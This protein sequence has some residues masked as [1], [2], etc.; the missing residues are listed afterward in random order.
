MADQ[1]CTL[2]ETERLARMVIDQISDKWSILVVATLYRGPL[3]FNALKREL[4]GVTQKALTQA[5]RRLERNGIVSRRVDPRP[6]IAVEYSITQLGSTLITPVQA[7]F[8]WTLEHGGEVEAARIR[9]DGS[10]EAEVAIRHPS[11][12][13][14]LSKVA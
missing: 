7:L 10:G 4:N 13:A 1:P 5:L 3:R 2:N 6:P 14:N 11:D 12:M 8:Q 9:Y